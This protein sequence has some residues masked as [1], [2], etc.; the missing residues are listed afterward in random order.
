LRERL[1]QQ[2]MIALYR[3]GRQ[4]EALAVYQSA[5][6]VLMEELGIE[7]GIGLKRLERA[8]LGQDA[9]LEPPARPSEPSAIAPTG[10]ERPLPARSA[11]H[12]RLLSA[13]GVVLAVALALLAGGSQGSRGSGAPA[14]AGPDT[15]GV[16]DGS[17]DVLSDVVTPAAGR[18]GPRTGRAPPGSPTPP[19]TCCCRSTRPDR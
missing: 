7:P 4:A 15:V 5:R 6:R 16:I 18:A 12:A 2:L 11:R 1:H 10:S 19:M 14:S 9:G 8:I 17:R 3:C 13:A